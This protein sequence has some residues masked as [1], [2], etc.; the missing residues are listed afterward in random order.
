MKARCK[1][2]VVAFSLAAAG[3]VIAGAQRASAGAGACDVGQMCVS[4]G[5]G[6]SDQLY[7][8]ATDDSALNN[9]D[10][11]DGGQ[12]SDHILSARDRNSSWTRAC[13]YLDFSYNGG[14]LID[15]PW[16]GVTWVSTQNSL[17]S[18]IRKR[19]NVGC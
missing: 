19:I 6:G 18:S 1:A 7:E 17:G 13:V 3:P 14:I 10:Y 5:S 16:A 9:N 2:L 4:R 11:A 12:V 15:A 8:F